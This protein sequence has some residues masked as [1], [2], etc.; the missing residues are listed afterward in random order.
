MSFF[1]NLFHKSAAPV[2]EADYRGYDDT[3]E[4]RPMF[5]YVDMALTHIAPVQGYDTYVA[6]LLE[7]SVNENRDEDPVD[8]EELRCLHRV[9]SACAKEG[10]RLGAIYAGHVLATAAANMSLNFYCR[11]EDKTAIGGALSAACTSAGR[12]PAK[13][14]AVEDPNWDLYF[15]RMFPDEYHLQTLNNADLLDELA[16]HGDHCDKSREVRYWIHLKEVDQVKGLLEVALPQGFA[17]SRTCDSRRERG[18]EG[19]TPERPVTLELKKNLTPSLE[20]LNA[21]AKFLIALA[22]SV[23]GHYDGCESNLVK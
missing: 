22:V 15:E 17:L 14:I 12:A 8:Q 9:E 18:M 10:R 11:A 13:V 5:V 3:Y 16:S 23:D 21:D 7:A 19:C 4:G 6:V 20:A 1:K 2:H